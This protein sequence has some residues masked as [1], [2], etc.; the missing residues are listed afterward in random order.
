M[1]YRVVIISTIFLMIFNDLSG[2]IIDSSLVVFDNFNHKVDS[3]GVY[4]TADVMPEFIGGIDEF[5]SFV[6]D[7]LSSRYLNRREKRRAYIG[8]VVGKNGCIRDIEVVRGADKRL[9]KSIVKVLK[10]MPNWQ[11]G[12]ISNNKVDVRLTFSFQY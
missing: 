1:D 5:Y 9:N 6:Q 4:L 12:E 7:N 2:Q 11:P 3:S 10:E 8:I